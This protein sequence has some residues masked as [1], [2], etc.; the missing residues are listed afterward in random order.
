MKELWWIPKQWEV[1]L[2]LVKNVHG[3]AVLV[4]WFF[5]P[6]QAAPVIIEDGVIGLRCI[7]VEVCACRKKQFF[8]PCLSDCIHKNH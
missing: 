4:L 5:E 8:V 6:L 7:V 3:V 2:K 1:V